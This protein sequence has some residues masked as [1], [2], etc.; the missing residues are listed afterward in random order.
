MAG[1]DV[2]I[3]CGGRGTRAY[4][5]TLE[6]PKPLLTVGALPVVE[7]V[8]QIYA[9]QGCTRFLLAAGYLGHLLEERYHEQDVAWDI[10]VIDTG[11]D[12][13]T[14]ERLRRVAPATRGSHFF[15]TYADGLGDVELGRLLRQH[16]GS[17]A[18]GTLTTVP[19]PSQYGTLV[20]GDDDRV[21]AFRE[22][23]RLDDHWINAGFFVFERDAFERWGGDDLERDVLP[24]MAADGEL[25]VHRH[26][27]FWKSMD[28][29]KD[30][31]ELTALAEAGDPPWMPVRPGP[32][33][34]PTS[35]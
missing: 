2:V 14:G 21:T 25:V 23:P 7:H 20:T 30:R 6:L 28:T 33:R 11:A 15:A 16:V 19:L 26:V 22:K 35:T 3:L 9:A 13:G 29:F 12:T 10:A 34:A 32:G 8:M 5:D 27:G 4:P 1:I 18:A 17:G 24:A 31:Q